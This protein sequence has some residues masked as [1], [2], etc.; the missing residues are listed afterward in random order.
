[1][2]RLL[3]FR[4]R[5]TFPL[6]ALSPMFTSAIERWRMPKVMT[7]SIFCLAKRRLK[8]AI[9]THP[10]GEVGA[11]ANEFTVLASAF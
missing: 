7:I 11:F 10:W 8:K 5:C 2:R 4:H 1:M 3:G 6:L 9:R